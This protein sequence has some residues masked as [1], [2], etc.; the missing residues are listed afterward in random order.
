MLV[1]E[2][3]RLMV[4]SPVLVQAEM[5]VSIY[6]REEW[7]FNTVNKYAPVLRQRSWYLL[8]QKDILVRASQDALAQVAC[9]GVV[10][11]GH[12]QVM[13]E[14]VSIRTNPLINSVDFCY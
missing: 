11:V 3:L 4:A 10:L 8:V 6:I 12:L 13:A 2:S 5:K 1:V 14:Y 9:A 7:G